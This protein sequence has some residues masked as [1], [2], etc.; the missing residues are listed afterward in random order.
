MLGCMG[1]CVCICVCVCVCVLRPFNKNESSF[2]AN[3]R[4]KYF[5]VASIFLFFLHF[6]KTDHISVGLV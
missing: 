5:K 2:K 1:V 6:K 4:L 3:L